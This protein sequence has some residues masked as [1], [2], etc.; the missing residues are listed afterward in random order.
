MLALHC[1]IAACCCHCGSTV[2]LLQYFVCLL[3]MMHMYASL[4]LLPYVAGWSCMVIACNQLCMAL[5]V[6]VHVGVAS[7][8]ALSCSWHCT[9]VC[10]TEAAVPTHNV[11][12]GAPMVPLVLR[13]CLCT[14][15]PLFHP[16]ALHVPA[17]H[18]VHHWGLS[19]MCG[20]VVGYTT[21]GSIGCG[22]NCHGGGVASLWCIVSSLA[23]PITGLPVVPWLQA[24][25]GLIA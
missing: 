4:G 25:C 9:L 7:W 17:W 19:Y 6:P 8:H 22:C 10:C 20:V 3:P 13:W 21:G 15:I 14:I 16:G 18:C 5:V 23:L 11:S 1:V 24:L 2:L 12:R